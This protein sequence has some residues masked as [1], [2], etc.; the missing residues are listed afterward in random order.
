MAFEGRGWVEAHGGAR[1]THRKRGGCLCDEVGHLNVVS[2]RAGNVVA[3]GGG[4]DEKWSGFSDFGR[5]ADSA[6][7]SLLRDVHPAFLAH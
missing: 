3:M 1:R 7:A 2:G 5:D 6:W 4:S